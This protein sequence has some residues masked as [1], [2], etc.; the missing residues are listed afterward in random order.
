MFTP[1]AQQSNI[2]DFIK[3][4]NGN[5][6]ITALAGTGKSTTLLQSLTYLPPKSK[7]LMAAFNK[8]IADELSDKLL[9]RKLDVDVVAKTFNSIGHSCLLK[10]LNKQ[11]TMLHKKKSTIVGTVVNQLIRLNELNLDPITLSVI[12]SSQ[13]ELETALSFA[14]S[15]G[16]APISTVKL[17]DGTQLSL[18]TDLETGYS[19]TRESLT[20][21]CNRY[22][23]LLD[24]SIMP[25]LPQILDT[26]L[27]EVVRMAFDEGVI[28][29][30]DQVYI[31]TLMSENYFSKYDFV[32]VDEAQD[33][34]GLRLAMISR[35][36]HDNSRIIFVG[37]KN[38]C[39]YGFTGS[40]IEIFDNI[41]S[42]FNPAHLPLSV[43]YRCSK[44]I[45]AQANEIVPDLESHPSSKAGVVNEFDSGW[46]LDDFEV[47]DL[48]VSRTNAPIVKLAWGLFNAGKPA[49]LLGK[50]IGKG[51]VGLIF[52]MKAKSLPDLSIRLREYLRTETVKYLKED[53]EYL[54]GVLEDKVNCIDTM[55]ENSVGITSVKQL[56]DTIN[57]RFADGDPDKV[58][59]LASIHKSK[60]L[61][62][63]RVWFV[64]Q[65]IIPIKYA[66]LDWQIEQEW[67]CK[68]VA[69][70]RAKN[71]LNFISVT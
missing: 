60:G 57:E 3:N 5:L 56:I 45:V 1:S 17:M 36:L 70:T 27:T 26:C 16:I 68:Y 35:T 41:D 49:K 51:L 52:K 59:R 43:T 58:I 38:Q 67:N 63:D 37:D 8:T 31:P 33:L 29:F 62:S 30:G 21:M 66:K 18:R 13:S 20:K 50:D 9:S 61:E 65:S 55:I 53:K 6:V 42:K 28:D 32:M 25:F 4:N 23:I 11:V 22:S 47:G 39:L 24:S 64:N 14:V 7:V 40:D 71:E 46:S 2:F 48:I 12:Q 15:M 54:I 10:I 69:I 34:S 44:L 19:L